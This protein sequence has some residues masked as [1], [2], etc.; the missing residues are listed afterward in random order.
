VSSSESETMEW[1]VGMDIGKA[2]RV[3]S[4]ATRLKT[5]DNL[6]LET[7]LLARVK[8]VQLETLPKDGKGLQVIIPFQLGPDPQP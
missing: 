7:C 8:E 3:R 1:A 6:A 4:A 5:F 2:G